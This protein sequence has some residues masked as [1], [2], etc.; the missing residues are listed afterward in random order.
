MTIAKLNSKTPKAVAEKIFDPK[1]K[2]QILIIGGG[3]AGF[4]TAWKLE[5]VLGKNEAEITLVDPLPYMTY[6]PF[7]PEVAAGSIEP[8]HVIVSHRQHLRKTTLIA[9]SMTK[10]NHKLKKATVKVPG[11]KNR[12]LEYDQIIMTAGAVTRTFPIKGVA[13]EAI[14]IKTVEE[15]VEI[16]N[17][18]VGNFERA[19]ALPKNSKTRRRLLTTVVVGGGFAGVEAFAELLSAATALVRY[20]PQ[21]DFEEIEFHLVEAAGRIMPEVS[22]KTSLW[23]I[24]NLE[25]RNARVH[26][27]TQLASADKGLVTLSTGQSMESGLIIWTAGVAAAPVVKNCDFPLDDR[28]RISANTKLQIVDGKKVIK[29]AWTAGDVAAVPD[30]SGG[31]VG[32][33]CVPNAQH[34]VRQAKLLAKNIVGDI[35]GEAPHEYHHKNLGAVA[36]LGIGVGVFQSGKIGLTG[37]VAWIAHR[38][39]HGLAMPTWERKIRVVSGWFWNI[40]LGRDLSSVEAMRNPRLFFETWAA[41]TGK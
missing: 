11:G 41:K 38:G 20:Y 37:F 30:T 16:R 29:G 9:G 14:G 18:M 6:Q 24:A 31:G 36:G 39:Y 13:E 35:R 21:I 15:A 19:A 26:L 40:F 5:K 33:Y 27:N 17:R 7:L 23:V 12:V 28:F 8:R 32:G 34:A 2:Q 10:V 22:L 1:P 25:K 4:Y 3:Y